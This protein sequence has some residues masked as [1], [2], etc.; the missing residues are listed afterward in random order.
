[1]S[2]N[3]I[4]K[5]KTLRFEIDQFKVLLFGKDVLSIINLYEKEG[6]DEWLVKQQYINKEY[7]K[8][9][10]F[11]EDDII[12]DPSD[13]SQLF[14]FRHKNMI[15]PDNLLWNIYHYCLSKKPIF[16]N[17]KTHDTGIK[18]NPKKYF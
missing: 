6:L 12:Y 5:R 16:K 7:R 11:G 4:K 1:M 13:E 18:L 15:D 8:I 9:F 3:R 17:H 14:N 2:T 10:W